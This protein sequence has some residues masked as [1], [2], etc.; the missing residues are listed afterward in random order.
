MEV[1]LEC[2]NNPE[3]K[4][5]ATERGNLSLRSLNS[6][7]KARQVREYTLQEKILKDLRSYGKYIVAFKLQRSSDN[8]VPDIFF[9]TRFT[10]PVFIEVKREGESPSELQDFIIRK[11]N[12][13]GS[14]AFV[15]DTWNEWVNI[16]KHLGF[17]PRRQYN[18]E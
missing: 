8:G 5:D 3:I 6:S 15:C 11:I 12:L 16:K 9:T 18:R 17:T 10:G 4:T 14:K 2:S 13:C 7:L 1:I